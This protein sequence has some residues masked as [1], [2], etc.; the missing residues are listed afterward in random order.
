[1]SRVK[2]NGMITLKDIAEKTGFSVNTVSH[3]LREKSDISEATRDFIKKTAQEMGYIGN[4]LASSMRSGKSKTIAVIIGDISNPLFGIM[5]KEMENALG[6]LGY[7]MFIM[8]TNEDLETERK[9]VISALSKNVDGLILCPS[10]K[11]ETILELL[12]NNGIPYILLGRRPNGS[13]LKPDYI[14]WND[15]EGGF[16]ATEH[17]LSL[18]HRRILCLNGPQHISSAMERLKG[19]CAAHERYNIPLDERLIKGLTLVNHDL[20]NV[21]RE[22]LDEVGDF[23]GIFAFSDMIAWET[24]HTL[25]KMGIKVPEDVSVVGFD[26]IQSK[27]SFPFGLT[28]IH[29]PKTIMA[30]RMV[31]ALMNKINKKKTDHIE[32][33]LPVELVIRETTRKTG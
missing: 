33:I 22:A 25:Q 26:D 2:A 7:N 5:V 28:T 14:V 3:A 27:M 16:L 6:E 8:N 31:D 12:E 23:T 24:I 20:E 29:T 32:D 17:L 30:A 13:K 19:Y 10:Q 15:F 1:M 21:I 11:D 18:G 4:A 9:T